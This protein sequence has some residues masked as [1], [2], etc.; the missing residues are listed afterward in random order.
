MDWPRPRG[1]NWPYP[2]MDRPGWLSILDDVA[3]YAVVIAI[4]VVLRL[5]IAKIEN[6]PCVA[7][8]KLMA[9]GQLAPRPFFTGNS[10]SYGFG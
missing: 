9:D 10:D 4:A 1:Q 8:H 7:I 2:G 3:I 6:I 5:S